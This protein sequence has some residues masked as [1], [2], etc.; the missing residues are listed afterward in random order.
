M[1]N[2]NTRA[3]VK[4]L[5]EEAN[6]RWL[7]DKPTRGKGLP[8]QVLNKIAEKKRVWDDKGWEHYLKGRK[9]DRI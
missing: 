9:W 1:V 5:R 2:K 8:A 7:E 3:Y 6:K 4:T